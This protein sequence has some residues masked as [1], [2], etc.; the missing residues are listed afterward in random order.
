MGRGEAGSV[1]EVPVVQWA[2][3]IFGLLEK[4]PGYVNVSQSKLYWY[5]HLYYQYHVVESTWTLRIL[6]FCTFLLSHRQPKLNLLVDTPYPKTISTTIHPHTYQLRTLRK[7]SNPSLHPPP[8]QNRSSSTNPRT[9]RNPPQ[10]GQPTQPPTRILSCSHPAH[11]ST[12]PDPT[13]IATPLVDIL[14]SVGLLFPGDR[15]LFRGCLFT[16]PWGEGGSRGPV[17]TLMPDT[18]GKGAHGGLTK[19]GLRGGG[20]VARQEGRRGREGLGVYV[21]T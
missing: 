4:G 12:T 7:P 21:L 10:K 20:R 17:A 14:A 8:F 9:E 13:V 19:F 15:R 18:C 5:R 2:L 1:K 16:L 11:Q 3:F 6:L